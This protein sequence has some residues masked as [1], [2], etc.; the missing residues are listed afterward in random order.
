MA[1]NGN[2]NAPIPSQVGTGWR[3][4]CKEKKNIRKILNVPFMK[5]RKRELVGARVF[6]RAESCY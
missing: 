6:V 5:V 1:D 4:F 3:S 2:D